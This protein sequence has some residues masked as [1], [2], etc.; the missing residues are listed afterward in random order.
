MSINILHQSLPDSCARKLLHINTLKTIV[1]LQSKQKNCVTS[2][3]K[4]VPFIL[5]HLENKGGLGWMKDTLH[6]ILI[7]ECWP[8]S[9]SQK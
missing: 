8:V 1:E 5:R 9:K 2:G 7:G 3:L 4:L 6:E